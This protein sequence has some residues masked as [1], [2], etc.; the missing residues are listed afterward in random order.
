MKLSGAL[1]GP[2]AVLGFNGVVVGIDFY[3]QHT[4]AGTEATL[5][6]ACGMRDVKVARVTEIVVPSGPLTVSTA[7]PNCFTSA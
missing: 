6:A 1:V 2:S 4:S 3:P 5:Q 7:A